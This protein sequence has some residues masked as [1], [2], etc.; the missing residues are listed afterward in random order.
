MTGP[1]TIG[2]WQPG[3]PYRECPQRDDASSDR[4][5]RRPLARA[6]H[7]DVVRMRRRRGV[8]PRGRRAGRAAPREQRDPHPRAL[9]H[10]D[11]PAR[12]ELT[13]RIAL[14]LTLAAAVLAAP[15][16]ARTLSRAT[17]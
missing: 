11:G 12:G 6:Q 2:L 7:R 13:P 3:P 5:R 16:F 9:G 8:G 10:L 15:A 4:F 17:A 14:V 1:T